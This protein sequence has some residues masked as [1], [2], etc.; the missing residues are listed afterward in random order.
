PAILVPYPKAMDDHQRYNA[1]TVEDAGGGWLMPED[2]FT[3][4]AL[5]G[6]L[7]H[8]LNLPSILTEAAANAHAAGHPDAARTLAKLVLREPLDTQKAAL[9]RAQ[10]AENEMRAD[11]HHKEQAA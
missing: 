10:H 3:A 7:E 6:K 8:F 9:K 1:N 2:G 4:E 11:H 5:S